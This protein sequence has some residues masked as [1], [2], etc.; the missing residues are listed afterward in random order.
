VATAAKTS[1]LGTEGNGTFPILI[2][3][4]QDGQFLDAAIDDV[5]IWDVARTQAQIVQEMNG[6][7]PGAQPHLILYLPFNEGSGATTTDLVAGYVGTLGDGAAGK[8]AWVT[9]APASTPMGTY[10]TSAGTDVTE[11]FSFP[12]PV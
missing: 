8:P 12:I 7:V 10:S 11:V 9:L 3:S 1:Y 6:Q 2:G 4:R 5:R